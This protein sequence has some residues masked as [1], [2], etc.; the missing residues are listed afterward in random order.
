ML[1]L[2][3]RTH[4]GIYGCIEQND[5]IMLIIKK[6]G[7][8]TGMYDLPGG[9]PETGETEY[10]TLKREIKEE[11]GCNLISCDNRKKKIIIYDNFK[12]DNG[13]S[14]CLVHTGILYN[15]KVDGIPDET[16]SDLDSNGALWLKK[17]DLNENNAT[18]FVLLCI[19][20][21]DK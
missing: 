18:P 2:V 7:P 16:I 4:R 11:T 15:C 20:F 12:E 5:K 3:T 21:Y 14:G 17:I 13:A 9:S 8:Y 6:R 1:K 10:Q 19:G